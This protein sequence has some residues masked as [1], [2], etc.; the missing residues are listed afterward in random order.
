MYSIYDYINYILLT[1]SN[2]NAPHCHNRGDLGWT[3][4][5]GEGLL[6]AAGQPCNIVQLIASCSHFNES[7][8]K[9]TRSPKNESLMKGVRCLKSIELPITPPKR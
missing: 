3:I 1:T 6:I 7:S 5:I 8:R 9:N 4:L 2:M